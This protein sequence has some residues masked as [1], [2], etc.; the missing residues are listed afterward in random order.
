MDFPFPCRQ[1]L[2]RGVD[3]QDQEWL[4]QGNFL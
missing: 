1:S 2:P 3:D 4:F